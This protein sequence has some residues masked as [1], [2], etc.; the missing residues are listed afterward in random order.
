MRR[1]PEAVA[2]HLAGTCK[3]LDSIPTMRSPAPNQVTE[4][5]SEQDTKPAETEFLAGDLQVAGR[6]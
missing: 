1:Q 6:A 3:A 5:L 4:R 2:E